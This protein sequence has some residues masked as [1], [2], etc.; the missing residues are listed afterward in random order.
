VEA[1]LRRIHDRD[2]FL[3]DDGGPVSLAALGRRTPHGVS[4]GPV[5]SPQE[6]RGRGYASACVAALS[7]RMLDQ[8]WAFCTLFTDLG[9]PTSNKIYQAVGY[10]PVCDFTEIRFSA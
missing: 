7:Q 3:W 1:I 4:I 2:V 9:N 5:F 8:G 6:R 10:R